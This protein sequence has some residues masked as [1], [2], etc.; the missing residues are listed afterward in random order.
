[1][2]CKNTVFYSVLLCFILKWFAFDH[3]CK[4]HQR[5]HLRFSQT[6]RW[7]LQLLEAQS[8]GVQL[9]NIH[10]ISK[11]GN[12]EQKILDKSLQKGILC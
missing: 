12:C 4:H 2:I 10:T 7:P 9:Q 1:M 8:Q 5:N 11:V 3:L 6:S